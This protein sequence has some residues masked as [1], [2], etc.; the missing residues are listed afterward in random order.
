MNKLQGLNMGLS[1]IVNVNVISNAGT[2]PGGIIVT[3]YC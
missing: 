1:N 3:K 2:I